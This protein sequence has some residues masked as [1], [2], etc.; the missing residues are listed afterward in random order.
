MRK[1]VLFACLMSLSA[2][3]FAA[4]T[5]NFA[6]GRGIIP[7][8][9]Q[10][11]GAFWFGVRSEGEHVDGHLVFVQMTMHGRLVAFVYL[12]EVHRAEFGRNEVHFGGPGVFNGHRVF[13]AAG[14][15]DNHGTKHPD[16]F[17][18][19]AVNPRNGEVVYGTGGPVLHGDVVVGHR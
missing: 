18:L 13:V 7:M 16:L 8:R 11:F 4:A 17:A 19:R 1:L 12:P 10:T 15:V 9:H 6:F 3:A 14:A 5:V 2:G